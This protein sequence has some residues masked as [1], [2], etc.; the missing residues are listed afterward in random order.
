[1]STKKSPERFCI[2]FNLSNPDHLEAV[3]ILSGKGRN[4]A[5]YIADAII[6]YE[7]NKQGNSSIDFSNVKGLLEMN[8]GQN[9]TNSNTEIAEDTF[10]FDEIS[11]DLE[12][13]KK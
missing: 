1:M 5:S 8:T 13:F 11:A 6:Y 7:K 12:G 2:R 4:V 10:D 9:I 3:N